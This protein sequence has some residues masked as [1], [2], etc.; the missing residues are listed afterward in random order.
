MLMAVRVRVTTWSLEM[1][2]PGQLRPASRPV[3]VELRRAEL[4]SPEFGRFLYATTGGNW[5]WIDR[6]SWTFERWLER[7]SHPRVEIWVLYRRGTPAGYFELD[8]G[9]E[10]EVEIAYLGLF[11]AFIG[12]G[13]GG[14]LLTEAIR[15][16]WAMGAGRVWVHTCTLD[17]PG[18]LANYRARGMRVFAEEVSVVEIPAEPLGPWPG[19]GVRGPRASPTPTIRAEPPSVARATEGRTPE[20]GLEPD[21]GGPAGRG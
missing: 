18:A 12:Q 19:A 5:Y 1:T 6:R 15:R 3:E 17:A 4:P 21:R 7:L 2:D 10:G 20:E 8:G 16:S 14:W 13:L 11:P 9:A